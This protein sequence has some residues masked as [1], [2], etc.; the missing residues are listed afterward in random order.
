MI[1][2]EDTDVSIMSIAFADEIATS[3]SLSNAEPETAQ[4]S[5]ISTE[6]ITLLVGM[7]TRLLLE[8][9]HILDV[10]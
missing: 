7:S 4:S 8:C 1:C 3:L 2:S 5:S 6:L 10:I 9:T